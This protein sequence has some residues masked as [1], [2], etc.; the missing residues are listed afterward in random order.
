MCPALACT[1][2]NR[3]FTPNVLIDV[4]REKVASE[5]FL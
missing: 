3:E 1:T 2:A 5:S 4:S